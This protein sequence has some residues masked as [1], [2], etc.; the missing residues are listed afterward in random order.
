MSAGATT[1]LLC[2]LALVCT[3]CAG[4]TGDL[5]S[6]ATGDTG[7][8]SSGTFTPA[9]DS[10]T[11]ETASCLPWTDDTR[12]GPVEPLGGVNTP[13]KEVAP[14]VTPDGLRLFFV[15]NRPGGGGHDVYV[16]TRPSLDAPFGDVTSFASVNTQ[17]DEGGL[18]L[19]SDLLTVFLSADRPDGKGGPDIWTATRAD[20]GVPFDPNAFALHTVSG[21]GRDY[22]PILSADGLRLYFVAD[23]VVA[24]DSRAD[25][26]VAE[27]GTPTGSFGAPQPVDGINGVDTHDGNPTLSADELLMVF[28]SNRTGKGT[29]NIYYATR[30]HRSAAFST[31][32]PLAA[33]NTADREGETF[34]TGD[35]CELYFSRTVNG[36]HDIYRTRVLAGPDA[37]GI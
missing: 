1:E 14:F 24:S 6:R 4:T 25:V 17:G 30:P 35:G 9:P 3:G 28:S 15:S 37:G 32:R 10:G 19:S 33:V 5:L 21:P 26:V 16:A 12:F 8:A 29:A 34:V 27:R 2:V 23:G 11:G 22:D 36:Q 13:Y 31:P 20:P 7:V 18:A